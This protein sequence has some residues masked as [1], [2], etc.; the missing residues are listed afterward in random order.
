MTDTV[1]VAVP[2][3]EW[4]LNVAAK[5]LGWAIGKLGA[6]KAASVAFA[7]TLALVVNGIGDQLVPYGITLQ[8]DA[9]VFSTTMPFAIFG[10][11]VVVHDYVKTKFPEKTWL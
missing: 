6:A 9:T 1:S 11:L 3:S 5:K 8:I 7:P 10:I 2:A 4:D